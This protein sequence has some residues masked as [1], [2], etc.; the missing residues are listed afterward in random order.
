MN[1]LQF[2]G[3]REDPFRLTPDRSFYFPTKGHT[4][5]REVIR[6]GLE[7]G[8]GFIII[9]GEVGTGKTLLLRMLMDDIADAPFET[10]LLLSPHLSRRELLLAIFQDLG[11]PAPAG[12]TA[13]LDA[14]L[15][16]LNDHLYLLT[17]QNKRLLL[18]IDEAQSLP[19]ESLEQLR[20]LSNF[21]TDTRK[22]LQIVLFGQPEL[23]DKLA[24]TSMR[25]FIQRVGIMETLPPLARQEMFD[26]INHRLRKSGG[27]EMAFSFPGAHLLWRY[28][29]GYPRLVNKIMSRALL[30]A[31][32]EKKP[33]LTRRIV[34]EAI[35]SF[36]TPRH[37]S[38]LPRRLFFRRAALLL[39]ALLLFYGAAGTLGWLKNPSA[40][41]PENPGRTAAALPL[42]H[43]P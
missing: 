40:A 36:N 13:S 22:L 6:Y 32:A 39:L 8:E 43:Q 35:A 37:P 38:P 28:T 31:C 41:Q 19:E 5:L 15:R 23:R 33:R 14:L 21:E 29:G 27:G 26:Y 34:R 2:F 4:A 25:Q 17:Q 7:E 10:A 30:M 9:T 20:L 16:L 1:H 18:I 24:Q 42:Q 12:G 11:L 3:L